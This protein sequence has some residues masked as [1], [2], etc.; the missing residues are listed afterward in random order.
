[1]KKESNSYI[2]LYS[3]VMV[4]IVAL[5]LAFTSEM[6][7]ERKSDNE[8]IDKMQQILRSLHLEPDKSQVIDTYKEVIVAEV[9]VSSKTGEELARFEGDSRTKS[10]AFTLNTSNQFKYIAQGKEEALPL[11]IATIDGSTKYI[12]PLDGAGLWGAIW[13]YLS[14]NE[15]GYTIYGSDFGHAGET[16]GLG[17]EI[18]TKAFSSQ[19]TNKSIGSPEKGIVGI[20]VVKP[21][22]TDQHRDYVDGIT[23]GTLTSN[24]VNDMIASCLAYYE[25]YFLKK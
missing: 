12:V 2:I 5:A 13:G 20:A 24:G 21:G 11:Y 7:K 15:D 6:L 22:Q 9:L 4:V 23:G 8:K 16:P 1:M 3:V 19:F 14:I 17:A 25:P 18:A 10:E